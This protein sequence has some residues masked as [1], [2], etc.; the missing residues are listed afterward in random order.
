MNLISFVFRFCTVLLLHLADCGNV[1]IK[2]AMRQKKNSCPN[3]KEFQIS[4]VSLYLDKS[5]DKSNISLIHNLPRLF[6][7]VYSS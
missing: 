2:V 6:N 7:D 1:V 3:F 4:E 5:N